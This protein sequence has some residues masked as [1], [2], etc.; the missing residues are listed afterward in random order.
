MLYYYFKVFINIYSIIRVR[1]YNENLSKY[2]YIICDIIKHLIFNTLLYIYIYIRLIIAY[3]VYLL[4]YKII[5]KVF[6]Y[7]TVL[8]FF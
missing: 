3:I 6:V 5:H 1:I 4:Y 7:L 2:L 8:H